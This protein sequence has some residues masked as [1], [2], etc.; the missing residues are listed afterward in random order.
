MVTIVPLF[1][2]ILK[3]GLEKRE[4]VEVALGGN[5]GDEIHYGSVGL[6]M[7]FSRILCCV[8]IMVILA[9]YLEANQANLFDMT[10]VVS[11]VCSFLN[12][13]CV[14]TPM[15]N[16]EKLLTQLRAP[17]DNADMTSQMQ[18]RRACSVVWHVWLQ[19]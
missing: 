3:D 5:F 8:T 12:I 16:E 9:D 7:G 17:S 4:N 18:H 13:K 15:N 1:K 19:G 2:S 11:V 6:V 14:W 10:P